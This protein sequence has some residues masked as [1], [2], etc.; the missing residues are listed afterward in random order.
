MHC[1]VRIVIFFFHNRSSC[2][3]GF[4]ATVISRVANYTAR[5]ISSLYLQALSLLIIFYKNRSYLHASRRRAERRPVTA[6][7]IFILSYCLQLEVIATPRLLGQPLDS[8]AGQKMSHA[9]KSQLIIPVSLAWLV[10]RCQA[11]SV[12]RIIQFQARQLI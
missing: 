9:K 6:G 11:P 5:D 3:I 7:W 1:R 12:I 8:F 10:L 2:S 4:L